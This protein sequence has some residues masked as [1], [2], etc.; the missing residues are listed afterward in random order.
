MLSDLNNLS[1]LALAWRWQRTRGMIVHWPVLTGPDSLCIVQVSKCLWSCPRTSF[2]IKTSLVTLTASSLQHPFWRK[3]YER[4]MYSARWLLAVLK[5]PWTRLWIPNSSRDVALLPALCSVKKCLS[6]WKL[7]VLVLQPATFLFCISPI[8]LINTIS[9]CSRQH[10]SSEKQ[11]LINQLYAICTAPNS[12]EAN[13]ADSLW[14]GTWKARN[15][16]GRSEQTG[17]KRMVQ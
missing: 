7:T 13:L 14:S 1:T 9:S 17:S 11:A 16:F 8:G 15:F 10:F 5:C 3:L 2:S 6:G 4:T 12:T